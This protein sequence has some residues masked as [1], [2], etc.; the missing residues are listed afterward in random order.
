[1]SDEL[2]EQHSAALE[3]GDAEEARRLQGGECLEKRADL[4]A[5]VRTRD[6]V[7][8]LDTV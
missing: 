4:V 7:E 2:L 5:H 3:I 1:M 6:L 8:K